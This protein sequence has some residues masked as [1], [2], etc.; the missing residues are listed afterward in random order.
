MP[1][2]V[3]VPIYRCVSCMH[4]PIETHTAV[5]ST[6][7]AAAACEPCIIA[8]M[9]LLTIGNQWLPLLLPGQHTLAW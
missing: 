3:K 5:Y 6:A 7:A 1:A 4:L 8:M 2:Q 9:P